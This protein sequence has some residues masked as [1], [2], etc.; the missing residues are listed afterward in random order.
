M[1]RRDLFIF[2]GVIV[3]GL[4][5]YYVIPWP[6]TSADII[7]HTCYLMLG[8]LGYLVLLVVSSLVFPKFG[9]WGDKKLF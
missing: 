1:N 4:L 5:S 8:L 9:N 7:R 2:G 3:W 6:T